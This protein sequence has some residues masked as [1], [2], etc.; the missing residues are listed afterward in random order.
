MSKEPNMEGWSKAQIRNYRGTLLY[1]TDT[2]HIHPISPKIQKKNINGGVWEKNLPPNRPAVLTEEQ[3]K[4]WHDVKT[5]TG[6]FADVSTTHGVLQI[7]TSTTWI[8]KFFWF[9][10]VVSVSSMTINGLVLIFQRYLK[11]PVKDSI[12]KEYKVMAFPSV[13]ICGIYPLQSRENDNKT[14]LTKMLIYEL[15]RRDILYKKAEKLLVAGNKTEFWESIKAYKKRLITNER[16]FETIQDPKLE[17]LYTNFKDM[18]IQCTYN[19][20]TCSEDDFEEFEHAMYGKCFTFRTNKFEEEYIAKETGPSTGITIIM[21][22][23]TFDPL[24]DQDTQDYGFSTEHATASDGVRMNIHPPSSMPQPYNKGMDLAPGHFTSIGLTQ[25]LRSTLIPPHGDCTYNR[26]NPGTNFSYTK[27][28]CLMTCLQTNVKRECG[29]F[30]PRGPI[31]AG[32]N[33]S[34]PENVYCGKFEHFLV[35]YGE[36]NITSNAMNESIDAD[37]T[38]RIFEELTPKLDCEN[39]ILQTFYRKYA[40]DCKCARPCD[41]I[42]YKQ[43]INLS[44][45]PHEKYY[46][47]LDKRRFFELINGNPVSKKYFEEK[48]DTDKLDQYLADTTKFTEETNKDIYGHTMFTKYQLAN[49]LI[50]KNFIK[51]NVYFQSLEVEIVS[52]SKAYQLDQVISDIGGVFGFYIGISIVSIFELGSLLMK[53]GKITMCARKP[54]EMKKR[55]KVVHLI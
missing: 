17:Y 5:A 54:E 43:V 27:D 11:F 6:D 10:V 42:G 40:E 15:E 8:T 7:H 1:G 34:L 13:T 29:C 36:H 4:E 55:Q 23:G 41:E 20:V 14:A 22:T 30:T 48:L 38:Q 21:F 39:R 52:S 2:S 12:M 18:V 24:E 31:P 25:T 26:Y 47:G 50:E 44:Q 3:L 49:K 37:Y 32:T 51:L 9:A 16:Y 35:Y 46:Q 53:I 28:T 45:W 19:G 33:L